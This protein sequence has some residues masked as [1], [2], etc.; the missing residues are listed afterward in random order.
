[1]KRFALA[2]VLVLAAAVATA[3]E[4][5]S[6]RVVAVDPAAGTLRLDELVEGVGTETREVER[7]VRLSPGINI[8]ILRPA[9]PDAA[10]WPNAWERR[11]LA[12]E[13]VKPGDFVTITI[14]GDEAIALDV[15]RPGN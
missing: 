10:R 13:E 15:V 1:M 5:H 6:G 11:P 3:A 2:L 7:T 4:R 8:Q 12:I 9:A 14:A